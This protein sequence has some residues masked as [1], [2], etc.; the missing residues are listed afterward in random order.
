MHTSKALLFKLA[1][2]LVVVAFALGG[3]TAGAAGKPGSDV[4]SA[5]PSPQGGP[6]SS[7]DKDVSNCSSSCCTASA[8]CPVSGGATTHCD[9]TGC[10]ATCAGG[11]HSETLC[12][13]AT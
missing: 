3:E 7:L 4:V 2:C 5:R 12:K 11:A 13:A 1:I 8:S 9:E 6:F 10:I